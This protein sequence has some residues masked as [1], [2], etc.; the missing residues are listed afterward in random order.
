MAELLVYAKNNWMDALTFEEVQERIS[1]NQHFRAKYVSRY[2]HG[3]IIEIRENGYW[4]E[5]GFNREAFV[6]IKVPDLD[7]DNK[8]VQSYED[9]ISPMRR[10]FRIRKEDLPTAVKQELLNTG[11]YT[12]TMAVV[13]NYFRNKVSE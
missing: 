3:D 10:R 12:T 6:V 9:E 4:S 2:Q 1:E 7:I 11:T 5:R 13:G 8:Y